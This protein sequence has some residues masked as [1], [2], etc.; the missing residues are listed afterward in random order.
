MTHCLFLRPDLSG[1]FGLEVHSRSAILLLK[2]FRSPLPFASGVMGQYVPVKSFVH[3][4]DPRAKLLLLVAVM[5]AV[6]PSGDILS[7]A[8]CAAAFFGTVKISELSPK[9]VLKSC[10]PVFL[11]TVFTFVFNFAGGLWDAGSWKILD[12]LPSLYTGG[13]AASR[14]LLLVLFA[15]LLP[16]TTAPL[17]LA[18]GMESLLSPLERFG[19]PAHEFAMMMSVALRFIPLL[20]DEADR[21]VK[22]Q[23]SRGARLD[24]GN[25]VQRMVAFFPVIIPLFVIIFKRADELA[26]AMEARGYRGGEGRTRRRPLAWKKR[27]TGATIFVVSV[28]VVFTVIRIFVIERFF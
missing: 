18:D 11:L 19:F 16:L 27:D 17:E 9:M 21:I 26:L 22:A 24:Q 15:V 5:A 4:L 12:W 1:D 23:L 20:M 6:F 25:A 8:C 7:L 2:E 14:L 28:I 10:R 13:V 3:S